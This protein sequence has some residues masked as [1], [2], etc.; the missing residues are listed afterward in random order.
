MATWKFVTV[1]ALALAL[2]GCPQPP[3]PPPVAPDCGDGAVPPP[4]VQS[5]AGSPRDAA[6]DAPKPDPSWAP[7]CNAMCGRLGPAGLNC[8]PYAPT[9]RKKE[10]CE[11][12]CTRR[13]KAG[14][15]NQHF[16]CLMVACSC[17]AAQA[18]SR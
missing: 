4:V 11:S 8:P 3:Q 10:P 9:P 15:T 5:D 14:D 7:E 2:A 13:L 1:L 17:T 18:C 12:V 6:T 16:P